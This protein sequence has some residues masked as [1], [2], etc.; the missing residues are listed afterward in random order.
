[1]SLQSEEFRAWWP[2]T[3]VKGFEEGSKRLRHPNGGLIDF[4][5]VALTPEGRPDLSLVTYIPR[6]TGAG[7]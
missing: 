1:L 6:H 2:E 5:Y 7:D 4:T 3:E